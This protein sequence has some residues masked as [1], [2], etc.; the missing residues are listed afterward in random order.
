M[1]PVGA[2]FAA[3]ARLRGDRALHPRGAVV[4]G[5]LVR[6]GLRPPTG[7]AWLDTAGEDVVVVRFSRAAGLPPPLPDVLGLSLRTTGPDG[8]A[9]DLLLS[10]SGRAP[11]SRHVLVPGRDPLRVAYSSLVPFSTS[12]GLLMVGATPMGDSEFGLCVATPLGRW[13]RFGVLTLP[14]E[15]NGEDRDVDFDP[16]LNAV[17]GLDML[18]GLDRL[19]RAAYAASRRGRRGR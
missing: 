3:V 6:H 16:V 5:V 2:A 19:R 8:R 11:G 9:H 1:G 4:E 18:P 15:I 14:A 17:P 7:V 12:H 10:S 13:R